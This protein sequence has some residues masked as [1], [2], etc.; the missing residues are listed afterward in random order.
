MTST[1]RSLREAKLFSGRSN[2]PLAAKIA[3]AF[4]KELG[5]ITI[6]NFSDGEIW[7]K[8]EENIRGTD[9]FLIQPTNAPSD[10]LLELLIMI[11]AAKRASAYRITAVIPYFGYA[12]QDRKDQPR[13]S[14]TAK[15]VADLI[16][17]TGADR[18]L[19]MDL[20]TP[21]IQG[22]FNIPVDHL[23][24]SGIFVDHFKKS[25]HLGNVVVASPD[26]GGI[27]MARS[28]ARRLNTSLVMLD[29]IRTKHNLCEVSHQLIGDVAGKDVL[30][31]DDLVDTGG[32][33]CKGAQL[34]HEKGAKHIYV[35][36][37]HGILSGQASTNLQE[38][39]ITRLYFS[40]SVEVREDKK[41][42]KFEFLSV[43]PLLAEGIKRIHEERS[44]SD[45]FP[46][47]GPIL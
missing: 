43:A 42:A 12:R 47:K 15:L 46:E 16:E 19:V 30:L 10:N 4:G 35:A 36:A 45:L 3:K 26:I 14:I 23:Y 34:L 20:H 29:K 24:G 7:V 9:V 17:Q 8:F 11:D 1:G 18:I 13:V 41:A 2:L 37:T 39:N 44:I 33:L 40:D 5:Q 27:H 25:M 38:S 31:V 32:T 22:Y 28:Y 6:K 21:Q